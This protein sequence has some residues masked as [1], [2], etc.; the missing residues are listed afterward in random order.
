MV[1][2]NCNG[3]V[4]EVLCLG[5]VPERGG[6]WRMR[7][8]Q[9]PEFEGALPS[10]SARSVRTHWFDPCELLGAEEGRRAIR[11]HSEDLRMFAGGLEG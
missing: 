1:A 10:V 11:Q 3:G 9:E 4:K 5:A 7:C 8:P 6:L 2:T